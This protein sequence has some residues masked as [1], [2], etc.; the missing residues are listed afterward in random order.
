MPVI[1]QHLGLLQPLRGNKVGGQRLSWKKTA[2]KGNCHAPLSTVRQ[3]GVVV[4]S[5]TCKMFSFCPGRH[6]FE[7]PKWDRCQ[8]TESQTDSMPF[9]LSLSNLAFFK[10]KISNHKCMQSITLNR[11]PSSS[12]KQATFGR[13]GRVRGK[14]SKLF[15]LSSF[16]YLQVQLFHKKFFYFLVCLHLF[17]KLHLLWTLF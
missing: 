13:V 3:Q 12:F 5:R 10:K 8:F 15:P 9:K 1:H 17:P 7:G 4:F 11:T 6:I 14:T 2:M 16:K